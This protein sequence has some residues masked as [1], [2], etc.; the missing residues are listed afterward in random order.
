M[1]TPSQAAASSQQPNAAA[2]NR[3]LFIA[4]N[5][6]ILRGI[7]SESVDLIATDP[8]FNKGVKAFEGIVTAGTDKEGKKV[9]YKDVWTWGDVQNEWTQTIK[10]DHQKLHA[11]I[12]A[13]NAA[14]GE[15]MGAFLCWLGVRVLEMHRILKPTGTLYLHLDHTAGAWGKAMLDAIFFRR[16]FLGEIVWNKQNGVKG[17]SAWGNEN[18]S[19]LCYAKRIGVHTFNSK[20]PAMRKPFA[21]TSRAMHF[22][23]VDSTGRHYRER[24]V[25][26]KSY[27]YYEDEGRFIGNL[28]N[29]IPS[30]RANT[31]LLKE[32]TRYPTQKPLAL[33]ERIV[34]ASSNEDDMVLDPFAGCA[35][36]CI[37]AELL[38]RKWIAIDINKEAREVVL[39]RLAKEARLPQG[40]QSW[41]RSIAVETEPPMR[42]DDGA[43]AAPELVLV[44]PTPKGPRMTLRE[45]RQ[46]LSD[47]EG[48]Y[49]QGCGWRPPND[50]LEY[51]DVDHRQP[52]SRE[53]KDSIRNRVLLCSPCNG[54]KSNKLTLAELRLK[55]IQEGRA[56]NETWTLGW[57]NSQGRFA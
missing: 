49:C 15:D 37:A 41:D 39:Q 4:D 9:S 19:I 10:D 23:Q 47:E 20:D 46:R 27:I 42:T 34:K 8:P 33:Y 2:L 31:P 57:Y 22:T 48:P 14:A 12:Q 50:L 32:G 55:R 21:K 30:M 1:P 5:L 52:K 38:G 51:L 3:T 6:P 26:G 54:V 53:G 43:E 25:N 44:S 56:L 29:D 35:T 13:A 40:S 11:V 7:D 16:N 45:L 28:W 18:D 17:R 24:V 36:T